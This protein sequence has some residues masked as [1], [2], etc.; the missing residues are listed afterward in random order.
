MTGGAHALTRGAFEISDPVLSPD[1]R[2]FY[3]QSNAVAPYSYDA[4]RIPVGGGELQR[5]SRFQGVERVALSPDGKRLLIQHSSPYVR[6]QIAVQSSDGSGSPHE[7]TDT[8]SDE[9]KSLHWIDPQIVQVPSTHFKGSVYAKVYRAVNEASAHH[10]AV[11]FV[12]G[13]GYL[14]DV[15]LRYSYYFREQM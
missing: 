11:I 2:W 1:G 4:Y 15:S 7:L 3:M 8:R 9:Y 5:V 6:S 10:P 13:A 14:Q 12:H